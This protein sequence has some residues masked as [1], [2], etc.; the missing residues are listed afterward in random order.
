MLTLTDELRRQGHRVQF[1]TFARRGLGEHVRR[2]GYET[3][4]FR[5]RAKIDPLA[6]VGLARFLRRGGFDLLHAHLSTSAV[7]GSLA[8]RLARV[9]SVASVHGLSGKLSFS[10][11]DH[12]IA[13]SGDVRRHLVAQGVGEAR[14]SIVPNG[15]VLP[16]PAPGARE[17]ARADLGVPPDAPVMGTVAR[18][19]P[20]KG[21]DHALHAFRRVLDDMPDARYVVL[22][23]GEQAAD[24]KTLADRL[25]I[26]G[27]VVF[28][29]YRSGVVG[30]LPGLDVFLFPTLREAMGIAIVEAMAVGLPVVASDTGGVPEVV[31]AET[32]LLVPPADPVAMAEALLVLLRDPA[33]RAAMGEAARARVESEYTVQRMAARTVGVYRSILA[34]RDP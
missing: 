33:R 5:V 6:I 4:E 22:G 2:L 16:S 24:L 25:G 14:V 30:L 13:V 20:L 34:R 15:L 31:T 10:A 12:L 18:L 32:G 21:V 19:T 3:K 1:G 17:R 23:D 27:S 9:P 11:C 8:A 26:A 29:G 7:N 28:A